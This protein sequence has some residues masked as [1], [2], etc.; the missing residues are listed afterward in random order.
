MSPSPQSSLGRGRKSARRGARQHGSAP[1]LTACVTGLLAVMSFATSPAIGTAAAATPGWTINAFAAP[2]NFSADDTATCLANNAVNKV[3][4]APCDAYSV[5]VTNAGGAA[6][7]GSPTTI[8][9]AV[10]AG[11]TIRRAALHWSKELPEDFGPQLCSTESQ[12]VRCKVPFTI[13]PDETVTLVIYLTVN[14][15]APPVLTNDASVAGGGAAEANV[16]ITNHVSTSVPKF[17]PS[18]FGF[19][20]NGVGGDPDTQAAGHPY[21]LTTTIGLDNAFRVNGPSQEN[22]D[23][24]TSVQDVKD[25]VVDLPLGLVGSTLAAPECTTAQLGSQQGCPADTIIGHIRTEPLSFDAIFSPIY[26]LVPEHGFPAEFGYHDTLGNSHVFYSR[27]VPTPS[28]YVLQTTNPDIPAVDLARIFVTFYGDPAA[29]QEELAEREG[30]VASPLAPVPLF[31]NPSDCTGQPVVATMYMDSWQNPGTYNPDGTPDFGDGKWVSATSESPPVTG[32]DLLQLPGEALVQPT[33]HEADKPTGLDFELKVPQSETVGVVGTPTLKKLV[34]KLPEGLTVD[35]AAGDGLAACSEAQIGWLGGSHLN[36]SPDP[37]ECPEASKIGS[38][39]LETPLVPHKFE[40]EMFLASQNENPFGATLAAYVV[41]NDPTTGVLIKIP[42]KF[43]ADPHTGQLTATFDENPNLPFS[44]LKLHFF[45]GPR[46]ELATPET[47]GTYTTSNELT[48][49]SFP[50]SGPITELLDSFVIDE[51]CPGGFNPSFAAGSQNLQAGAYTPFTASFSRADTDQELSGLTVT[52]PPGL[53]GKIA[54]VP[55]CTEAQIHA[56]ETGSGDCPE[57]SR[58][59]SVLAGTGPG[60][61]PLFVKGTAYLTGPYN[62]GPYGLAVVVPAIAGPYNF[63]TVVVRQSLRIDPRTAQVTDVSDP[64]PKIIDGIPLRLRRV[65]LTLDRPEFTFNPTSC[66][67]QQLSGAMTGTPLGAPTALNGTIGY[68]TEAGASSPFTAPFQV[69][70]C[71]ALAFQPKIAVSTAGKASKADGASLSF[72]I[73]YPKGALGS[74]ANF[75]EAKFDL[76]IQLPARLT[77]LQKACL[78]ANFEANPESCPAAST[79][80]HAAVHTQVLP[81]PLEGPV[82]FVSYGAAK[83]PEAVLVLKG[84]NVTVDLHG[85][86]FIAKNGLTSATFHNTPDVPFESIE[87][88]IPQGPFSEFGANLPA[89][90]NYNLCGQKLIMPTLFKAQNGLQID[91]NTPISVTGCPK[92][93]TRTQKLAA[94]LKACHKKHGKKRAACEKAVR[95]ANSARARKAN[96]TRGHRPSTS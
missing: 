84:D 41:V 65:D 57:A 73:A 52:L 51:A 1:I 45:G 26:N 10:P 61:N 30:K 16:E 66:E 27:V 69:T 18:S 2:T 88:T 25:V 3:E 85:E 6:S 36:F 79:V 44:D 23:S 21:E 35:P 4:I 14:A 50:D 29:K 19:R 15:G 9:D 91:E 93:P 54:G 56:I 37:P 70:N 55:L 86:T 48:P 80:G 20:L 63:G 24:T 71:A 8:T 78:A 17:G 68:A 62:G 34:T 72:K 87:V 7:D 53:I 11:L 13:A 38:L 59:G 67:H 22:S 58:V 76:P 95:T 33:S 28:G 12:T 77:T 31:T 75:N 83:F 92:A 82:Y 96:K 64:F 39:E 5:T 49:Y 90:D 42:G 32:C 60:P 74:Q 81:V 47:C 94:A 43:E 46:A 40:G 89:K